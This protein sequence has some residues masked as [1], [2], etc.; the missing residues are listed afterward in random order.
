MRWKLDST[1]CDKKAIKEAPMARPGLVLFSK[2][3]PSVEERRRDAP[4]VARGDAA[5]AVVAKR[6]VAVG[7]GEG[8][9]EK[10]TRVVAVAI[11]SVGRGRRG[12]M[13]ARGK[14][15]STKA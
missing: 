5:K 3:R 2:S 13:D 14:E 11:G 7:G 6:A 1:A 10:E 12:K 15:G 4:A 9:V 8:K